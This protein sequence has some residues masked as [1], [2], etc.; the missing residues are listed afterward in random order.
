M[1]T[2]HRIPAISTSSALADLLAKAQ[3]YVPEGFGVVSFWEDL[4]GYLEASYSAKFLFLGDLA[5]G[6]I[7]PKT[8]F[9]IRNDIADCRARWDSLLGAE[10]A[11]ILRRLIA[12]GCVN[13]RDQEAVLSLRRGNAEEDAVL[14]VYTLILHT[15]A[16]PDFDVAIAKERI[17]EAVSL[18]PR[19]PKLWFHLGR[20]FFWLTS[21]E[22]EEASHRAM[23]E[24]SLGWLEEG[25]RQ[26][27]ADPEIIYARAQV[28][29]EVSVLAEEEE[30]RQQLLERCRDGFVAA[31]Q[32]FS[33]EDPASQVCAQA[34]VSWGLANWMLVTECGDKAKERVY[35]EEAHRALQRH[36]DI[37]A[38]TSELRSVR[39]QVA[40]RLGY[41]P[42]DPGVRQRLF[43]EAR[44]HFEAGVDADPD[45]SD[46]W[47]RW[48]SATVARAIF[49]HGADRRRFTEQAARL[50]E[51]ALELAEDA[52][53]VHR[54]AAASWLRLAGE[55]TGLE[56]Q[57]AA[58]RA[59]ES[60][61]RANELEPHSQD[62]NLACALS[63]LHDYAQAVE[64]LTSALER[65]PEKVAQSLVDPDLQPL[66][67][68]R[69]DLRER[70]AT[71]AHRPE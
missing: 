67:A 68:A 21:R 35:L 50:F 69:A 10:P 25:L 38:E 31:A 54:R 41:L 23:L 9:E 28:L 53:A 17:Q 24:D 16:G 49:F 6:A 43:D 18:Q 30:E 11:A 71:P 63:W 52:C 46:S 5:K 27:P 12:E 2:A 37:E 20:S 61:R 62:Y 59:S 45:D 22:P 66:W 34:H 1:T 13:P 29:L 64:V 65:E 14:L 55:S 19:H 8:L 26:A 44:E 57:A 48:A 32:G 51:Q 60:A 56:R 42:G 39:G 7:P 40:L 36:E 70:F 15:S 4:R 3:L 58:E 33:A 47:S